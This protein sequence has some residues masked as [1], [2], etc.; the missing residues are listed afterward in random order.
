MLYFPIIVVNNLAFKAKEAKDIVKVIRNSLGTFG[1]ICWAI[2]LGIALFDSQEYSDLKTTDGITFT[3]PL[4]F[5]LKISALFLFLPLLYHLARMYGESLLE[6]PWK[7]RLVN[8]FY[9]VMCEF[10]MFWGLMFL[11]YFLL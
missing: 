1:L 4:D 5:V 2:L 8:F 11:G 9:N 6:I 7:T 10:G 3:S